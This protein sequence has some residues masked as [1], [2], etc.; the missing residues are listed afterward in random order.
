MSVCAATASVHT[1]IVAAVSLHHP[2]PEAPTS[3]ITRSSCRVH[4]LPHL[5]ASTAIST[6]LRNPCG[7]TS[8]QAA[9]APTEATQALPCRYGPTPHTIT[10]AADA[11]AEEERRRREEAAATKRIAN[12]MRPSRVAFCKECARRGGRFGKYALRGRD[13][14]SASSIVLLGV[15][16]VLGCFV[17]LAAGQT[18]LQPDLARPPMWRRSDS[19][20]V[21]SR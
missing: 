21:S 6:A 18:K 8:G 3:E 11:Q 10:P 7:Y 9:R 12:T 20:R 15:R 1:C 17:Q 5:L 16:A 19:S 4:L 14:S 2:P 13:T